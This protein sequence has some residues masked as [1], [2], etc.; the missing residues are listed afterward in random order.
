MLIYLSFIIIDIQT[1]KSSKNSSFPEIDSSYVTSRRSWSYSKNSYQLKATS[2]TQQTSC[3]NSWYNEPQKVNENHEFKEE[4]KL[5]S[6]NQKFM[7]LESVTPI[8]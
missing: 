4:S 5:V 6:D 2:Y 8:I 3:C 7:N 1:K